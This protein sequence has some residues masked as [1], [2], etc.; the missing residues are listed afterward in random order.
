MNKQRVEALSDGIFAIVLTLLVIEIKVPELEHFTERGLLDGLIHLIPLFLSFFLSFAVITSTWQT[1]HFLF[2]NMAK[3]INRTL[4]YLNMLF[5]FFISLLPFSSHLLGEYPESQVAV[6]FYSIN[7]MIIGAMIYFI[8]EFIIRSKA[9]ENSE[10][11]GYDR[12]YGKI[13]ILLTMGLPFL[14]IL[15]SFISTQISIA[16]I[17][18]S[19]AINVTPGIVAWAAR[20]LALD[21]ELREQK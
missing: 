12:L 15:L 21:K 5:L 13:R 4:L 19:V 10:L 14:A 11:T 6:V 9:I 1:H 18:L 2:T 7:V 16:I 8:R 20:V 3:N 17:V